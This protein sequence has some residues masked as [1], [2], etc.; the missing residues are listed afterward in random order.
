MQEMYALQASHAEEVRMHEPSEED[1][2]SILREVESFLAQQLTDDE[3]LEECMD[4][5]ER[6]Y[7]QNL[8]KFMHA[9]GESCEKE[10]GEQVDST[11]YVCAVCKLG[12]VNRVR[13]KQALGASTMLIRLICENQGCLVIDLELPSTYDERGIHVE[14]LMTALNQSVLE[15]KE[16]SL[17]LFGGSCNEADLRVVISEIDDDLDCS[18]ENEDQNS[19]GN[20]NSKKSKCFVITC[21]KC[22]YS[23]LTPLNL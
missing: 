22:D 11:V 17:E 20:V 10:N 6:A 4:R 12:Y 18:M 7:Q 5:E 1:M 23:D 3:W 19:S 14:K 16:R 13:M 15:H 9:H 21:D 2:D 8:E